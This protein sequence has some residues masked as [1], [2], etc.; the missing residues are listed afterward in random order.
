M[1]RT[2]SIG[3]LRHN[4]PGNVAILPTAA[5]RKVKQPTG[6]PLAAAKAAL[7]DSQSKCFPFKFPYQREAER[8]GS[9]QLRPDVPPFDPCNPDHLGAWEAVWDLGQRHWQLERD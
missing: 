3:D 9:R 7:R 6:R 2:P 4:R 1:I 5:T 8:G